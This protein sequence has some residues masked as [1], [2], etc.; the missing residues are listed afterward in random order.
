MTIQEKATQFVAQFENIQSDSEDDKSTRSSLFY[1]YSQGVKEATRW[2]PVEESLPE[3]NSKVLVRFKLYVFEE[4]SFSVA[5]YVNE[6]VCCH[7]NRRV[8]MWYVYPSRGHILAEVTHWRP[9]EFE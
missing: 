7:N 5:E 3:F 1:A 6:S 4:Y 8:P 2:I 9:L